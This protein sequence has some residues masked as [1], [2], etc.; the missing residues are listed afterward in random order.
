MKVLPALLLSVLLASC[1]QSPSASSEAKTQETLPKVVKKEETLS[2][3]EAGPF[4]QYSGT[5]RGSIQ[6]R[7][8]M[9][10]PLYA[11]ARM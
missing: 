4:S 9:Q 6:L 1:S 8:K 11:W 5:Y 3:P 2:A 10:A 7:D